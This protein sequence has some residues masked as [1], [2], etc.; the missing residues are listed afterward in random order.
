MRDVDDLDGTTPTDRVYGPLIWTLG[1]ALLAAAFALLILMLGNVIGPFDFALVPSM[2]SD[3]VVLWTRDA[4]ESAVTAWREM[5]PA[6]RVRETDDL[7]A[8]V[9]SSAG[10]IAVADARTLDTDEAARLQGAVE[11]GT[12]VLL[13]G[14]IGVRDHE[15]RWRGLETMS[16]LLD[17]PDVALLDRAPSAALR[18]WHPGPLTARL[19]TTET[20]ELVPEPGVPA[21]PHSGQQAELRWAGG[22][23]R[24]ERPEAARAASKRLARG[25]GRLVWL[26][27]GPAQRRYA[28]QGGRHPMARLI[29]GALA[30][31][32]RRAVAS[33]LSPS[34]AASPAA[35][36]APDAGDDDPA[37]SAP[38]TRVAAEVVRVGPRRLRVDVTNTARRRLQDVVVRIYLNRQVG[39]I[40]VRGTTALQRLPAIDARPEIEAV[41]L[42]IDELP[43]RRSRSWVL[44]H[45]AARP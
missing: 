45:D 15:G 37:A 33:V 5:L 27:A 11:N 32:G 1:S 8:A 19:A 29:D 7:E 26:G 2:R 3:V 12:G 43:A 41:D 10:V 35:A 44:D 39:H 36:V 4:D 24:D 23:D 16:A 17:E 18:V 28:E 40:R 13:S 42:H 20:L 25:R 31:A 6:G 14:A 30:W 22:R 34:P 9:A 38:A 21:L